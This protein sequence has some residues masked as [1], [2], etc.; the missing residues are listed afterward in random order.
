M[1]DRLS[2]CGSSGYRDPPEFPGHG[3]TVLSGSLD[4]L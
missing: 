3:Y 2:E 4:A 1:R